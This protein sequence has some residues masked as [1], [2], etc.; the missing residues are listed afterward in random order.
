MAPE[1]TSLVVV[2]NTV[3]YPRDSDGWGDAVTCDDT[4]LG[5]VGL[6]ELEHSL[7]HS[8]PVLS[9]SQEVSVGKAINSKRFFSWQTSLYC[10]A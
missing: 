10:Y 7:Q 6:L 9:I 8:V 1:C 5:L 4:R 3:E 2:V